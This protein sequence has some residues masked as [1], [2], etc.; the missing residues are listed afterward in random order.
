MSIVKMKRLRLVASSSERERLMRALAFYGAVELSDTDVGDLQFSEVS[1]DAEKLRESLAKIISAETV[2]KKYGSFKKGMF[3]PRPEL[4]EKDIFSSEL[5]LE[6]LTDAERINEAEEEISRL[7]DRKLKLNSELLKLEPWENLKLPL[8]VPSGRRY[9]SSLITAPATVTIDA[10]REAMTGASE[11]SELFE[12]SADSELRYMLLIAYR[13]EFDKVFSALKILGVA[14]L[15]FRGKTETAKAER[16]RLL[17][18]IAETDEAIFATK[19]KIEVTNEDYERLL[20]AEDALQ[21][22]LSCEVE[23]EKGIETGHAFYIEGWF[24]KREEKTLSELL[25]KNGVAYEFSEPEDGD[26]PP[27]LTYNSKM[28]APFEVVTNMY[29][30]PA[31]TGIDPNPV[32]GPFFALFFGIMLSDA[33]YGLLLMLAGIFALLKMNP[34]G[35]F[36]KFMQLAIIC[37][38]STIVWGLLFG[39]FF[40]NAIQSAYQLFTG[41]VFPYDMALWFDPSQDPMKMLIFSMALGGIQIVV[42]M[43]VKGYMMIRDGQVWDAI[44][45]IGSWWLVF[46]GAVTCIF[47]ASVGL[48]ILIAGAA[49]LILTQGRAKKNIIMKFLSG[50]MSLY[51]VTGY[52]SDILSYSRLL[53]LSLATAVVSQ[54]VNTMGMLTG[55]I[56]FFIVLIIGHVFNIAINLIGS[57]VHSARLQYVEFFGRFYESGGRLFAPLTIKTKNTDIIK[58]EN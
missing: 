32:M 48:Y 7:N 14:S 36:K 15:G 39:G 37:G 41:K 40:G 34:R 5:V 29:S 38:A 52:F 21:T 50:V 19:K 55:P 56:G 13:D 22:R 3:S 53:A 10:L 25:E 35:G 8:D 45:D 2:A 27:T 26:E 58:E 24:P 6:A 12:I 51:D 47:N 11:L 23:S 31:Y 1:T 18:E 30:A 44:F 57:F 17:G 46:A 54:V 28:I 43:A 20:A 33:A 42:S 49:A 9:T 4:R 16:Q